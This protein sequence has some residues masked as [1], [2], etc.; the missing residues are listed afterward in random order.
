[1][2]VRERMKIKTWLKS[3]IEEE[4]FSTGSIN[5]ILASDRE[6]LEMNRQYRSGNY[7]TDIITFDYTEGRRIS[8]DLYISQERI[9]ENA[10]LYSVSLKDEMLRVIAHGVLHLMGYKDTSEED[11][12]AMRSKEDSC[13]AIYQKHP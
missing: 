13:L 11:I 4:G 10:D 8:G 7:L 6:V 9:I 2:K 1:V 3:I 12:K 5:I